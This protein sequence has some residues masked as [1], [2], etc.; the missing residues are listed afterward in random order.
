MYGDHGVKRAS[1][2]QLIGLDPP[3]EADNSIS[4]SNIDN[5]NQVL[6]KRSLEVVQDSSELGMSFVESEDQ[7]CELTKRILCYN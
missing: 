7:L 3:F 4:D 6:L 5:M 2:N 1:A